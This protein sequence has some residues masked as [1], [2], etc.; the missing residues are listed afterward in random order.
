MLNNEFFSN[1]DLPPNIKRTNDKYRGQ[2]FYWQ[3]VFDLLNH[4]AQKR[5]KI[6]VDSSRERKLKIINFPN[7]R[8]EVIPP[9]LVALHSRELAHF[10]PPSYSPAWKGPGQSGEERR[11]CVRTVH[12]NKNSESENQRKREVRAE[13]N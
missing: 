6:E 8:R 2:I 3:Y 7:G 5:R 9:S 4:V 13:R 10:L 12:G 1:R 11:E